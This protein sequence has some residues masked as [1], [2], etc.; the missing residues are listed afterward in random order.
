MYYPLSKEEKKH[1]KFKIWLRKVL[2][3]HWIKMCWL[4]FKNIF[5]GRV[6]ELTDM[7]EWYTFDGMQ[8]CSVSWRRPLK[9]APFWFGPAYHGYYV[10]NWGSPILAKTPAEAIEI[11]RDQLEKLNKAVTLAEDLLGKL[12][13]ANSNINHQFLKG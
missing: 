2:A 1:L 5:T 12:E 10:E 11:F 4:E 13:Q 7:G 3:K 9:L 8:V 6:T